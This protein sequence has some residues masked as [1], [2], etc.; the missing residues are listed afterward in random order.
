MLLPASPAAAATSYHYFNIGAIYFNSPGDDHGGNTSVNGE[1]F[2]IKNIT[3]ASH[4]ISGW[5]MS[6]L[7]GHR[8]KFP[9]ITVPKGGHV[10]VHT[11]IGSQTA[12]TRHWGLSYYVWNNDGDKGTLRG[13]SG[14]VWDTCAYAE[15]DSPRKIC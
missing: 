8:Y 4:T 5:T 10:T 13:P 12:T 3:S 14:T 7:Q 6:D 1:F 9:A 2:I 15:S 11:G